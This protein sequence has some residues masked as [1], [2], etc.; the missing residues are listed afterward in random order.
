LHLIA[1]GETHTHSVGLLWT[2]DRPVAEICIS[3]HH[4]THKTHTSITSAGLEPAIPA[5]ERS[6]NTP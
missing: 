3:Q 5:S 1:L 4:N 2:R 6:Q